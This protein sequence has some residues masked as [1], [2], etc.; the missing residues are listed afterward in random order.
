MVGRTSPREAGFGTNQQVDADAIKECIVWPLAFD[1]QR[2]FL[3]SGAGACVQAQGAAC[4]AQHDDVA[5]GD[6]QFF[7]D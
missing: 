7:A 3:L 5:L 1:D 6:A 2:P 4:I